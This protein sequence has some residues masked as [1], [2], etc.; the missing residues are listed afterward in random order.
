MT[1][2]VANSET[3]VAIE[4][5]GLKLTLGGKKLLDDLNL[6]IHKGQMTALL[7]P[8]GA[9][10]STLLKVLC[11]EIEADGQV[12]LFG[13]TCE[14]WSPKTLAKHLGVLPQHSNLSFAFTAAEVVE[15]GSLPLEL[16]KVKVRALSKQMMNR[17][18]VEHLAS[19]LYPTLS[20]G[21][22]QRV[23]YARV[24]SQLSQAGDNCVLILDEPTSA[25]DLSHQH[26]TL[27]IAQELTKAGAAVIVVIHDLNLAAQYADRLIILK[28]GKIQADG[29]PWQSLQSATI[30]RIY[31]W[32]VY[33]TPHPNGDY[34]VVIPAAS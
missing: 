5:R 7:G 2:K 12:E 24:L 31:D 1:E 16:P 14:K 27:Q 33:I 19:R 34:P 13:K 29:T 17:V 25:L 32:P 26:R 10:K 21:E 30:Q 20:G 11:G 28:D 18:G 22:K 15:L 8:N 6:K 4:G 23:H 9:G 3:T